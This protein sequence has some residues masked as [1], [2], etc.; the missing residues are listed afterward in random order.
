MTR[1]AARASESG[2]T[3]GF[4]QNQSTGATVGMVYWYTGQW[5]IANQTSSYT[6]SSDYVNGVPV[7]VSNGRLL[8]TV[9]NADQSTGSST[10][11]LAQVQLPYID[12][13]MAAYPPPKA[14][15]PGNTTITFTVSPQSVSIG[16][17]IVATTN[18]GTAVVQSSVPIPADATIYLTY[19]L[20]YN[21][22]FRAMPQLSVALE[23]SVL[24]QTS[25]LSSSQTAIP[26]TSIKSAPSMGPDNM[27]Y[28]TAQRGPLS[29][30][31]AIPTNG[32]NTQFGGSVYG[33]ENT[34][35][36]TILFKWHYMPAFRF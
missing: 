35:P 15:I 1:A 12:A 18:V 31:T 25:G 5:T 6:A 24:A 21:I 8:P 11:T 28:V 9:T 16:D 30:G 29:G 2:P 3:F 19:A 17:Q 7:Y 32:P 13:N 34:D 36:K 14:E 4:I 10:W 23:P 20:D 33:L 22:P 27:L 26:L